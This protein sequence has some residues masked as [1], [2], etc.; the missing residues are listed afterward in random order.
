LGWDGGKRK[1][2]PKKTR[3]H[4]Q[5]AQSQAIF[6]PRGGQSGGR[7]SG[8]KLAGKSKRHKRVALTSKLGRYV[9]A[10]QYKLLGRGKA[11][12]R[13]ERA[14][15]WWKEGEGSCTMQGKGTPRE[16][17]SAGSLRGQLGQGRKSATPMTRP[18]TPTLVAIRFILETKRTEG[19]DG[20]NLSRR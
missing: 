6:I 1:D 8:K 3:N 4:H 7:E 9:N 15:R 13:S 17:I 16:K 5:T 14:P 19:G 11:E 10:V 20:P 18:D 2:N 12:G